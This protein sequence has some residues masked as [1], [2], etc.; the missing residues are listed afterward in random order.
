MQADWL[1]NAILT[2]IRDECLQTNPVGVYY[3]GQQYANPE[4]ALTAVK[5]VAARQLDLNQQLL[6]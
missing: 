4:V 5:A 2:Y 3:L 1:V 6:S